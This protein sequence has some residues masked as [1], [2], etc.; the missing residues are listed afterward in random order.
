MLS[1]SMKGVEKMQ[2][3]EIKNFEGYYEVSDTGLVRSLDRIVYDS[4][5]VKKF[6]AG[7]NL[8]LCESKSNTRCGDGYY[9]VNLRKNSTANVC[10]VHR[11]VAEAFIPNPYL[12]PTV[13]HKNGNKHDNTKANL[14]W[15]S[16]S[17]NNKHAL[18]LNLRKPKTNWIVQI[19]NNSIINTFRSVSEA[20]K[21]TGIGRA[22]ISHCVNHRTQTAGGYQW[23]KIEKCND[24]LKNESTTEDELL[25]EVQERNISED[26]VY[27]D[28]NI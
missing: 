10:S 24:Y 2:W 26:I 14:E 17:D 3:K 27:T 21:H 16:F 20:S 11:L 9:V 28:R 13:N 23:E 15:A 25:L 8:K 22:N 6:L 4:N 19:Y 5:G 18:S 7:K 1:Q 12:L